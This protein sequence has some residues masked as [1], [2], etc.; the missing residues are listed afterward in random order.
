MMDGFDEIIGEFLVES[1]ENLDRLDLE[2]IELESAPGS[3][4]LLASIF[5]TI[6]TIKGTAGFL[7]LDRLEAVSHVGES[8]LSKLRDGVLTTTPE[9]VSALLGMVDAVR[10]MLEVV[11]ATGSD[12]SEPY[13]GLT[14]TLQAHIDGTVPP[15]PAEESVVAEESVAGHIVLL[16]VSVLTTLR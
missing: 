5:R 12:G 15:A 4:E 13:A 7:G 8:L 11:E 9:M 3:R 10:E 2:F 16:S 6:H 1:R 14:A